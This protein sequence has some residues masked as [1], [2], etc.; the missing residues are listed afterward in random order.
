MPPDFERRCLR[1]ERRYLRWRT[2]G[3]RT[4]CVLCVVLWQLLSFE[5]RPRLATASCAFQKVIDTLARLC[6]IRASFSEFNQ[7]RITH[8]DPLNTRSRN[9]FSHNGKPF[10][11]PSSAGRRT[12][13]GQRPR[14]S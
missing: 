8:V 13:E 6:K 9:P 4:C 10:C 7:A 5:T 11:F 12:G 1:T 2:N 14:R 3:N